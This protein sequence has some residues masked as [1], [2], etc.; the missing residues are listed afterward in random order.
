[1]SQAQPIIL[2]LLGGRFSQVEIEHGGADLYAFNVLV[3]PSGG[4]PEP[5]QAVLAADSADA[6][7]R[8]LE[9]L[10]PDFDTAK[11][12]GG[13]KVEVTAFDRRRS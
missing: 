8:A 5:I 7:L 11:P 1:M 3:T 6:V 4:K 9:L 2:D 13:L 10:Y 12:E